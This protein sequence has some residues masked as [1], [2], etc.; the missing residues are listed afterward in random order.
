MPSEAERQPGVIPPRKPMARARRVSL[1]E[2]E[3]RIRLSSAATEILLQLASVL[4][5]GQVEGDCF[6]GSTM[7]TIDLGRAARL[8]SDTCGLA[9]ARRVAELLTKDK[10]FR[11]RARGLARAEAERLAGRPLR[12]LEIDLRVRRNG[13]HLQLDMDVEANVEGV[14]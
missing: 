11:D 12:D 14:S 6:F 10:R 4:S 5:E 3:I 9:A 2:R 1:F 7:M 13:T 8:V